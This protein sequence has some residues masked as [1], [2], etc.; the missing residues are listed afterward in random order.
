M[1]ED[2]IS[3]WFPVLM[4]NLKDK[5]RTWSL[6]GILV[7]VVLLTILIS[8][9]TVIPLY[10]IFGVGEEAAIFKESTMGESAAVLNLLFYISMVILFSVIL[11]LLLRSGKLKLIVIIQ[12]LLLSYLTASMASF[13]I[14]IWLLIFIA[15]LTI[16]HEEFIAILHSLVN[17]FGVLSYAIFVLFGV[18]Q[19]ISLL[20]SEWI[21]LRNYTL[22]LSVTWAGSLIG[23]F[24]GFYTPLV[25]MI[26]FVLYDI[27]AVFKGPIK[28]ISEELSKR[29]RENSEKALMLGLGDIFFYSL[30]VSYSLAYFGEIIALVVGAA[31]IA[32]VIITGLILVRNLSRGREVTLPALPIPISLA[33]VIII[34]KILMG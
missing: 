7:R 10:W 30:A 18:L 21:R 15:F 11:Y 5:K 25:L 16:L 13:V 12:V 1:S 34:L 20:K 9:G 2:N 33:V 22:L 29:V 28:K 14:P 32:G 23:L 19:A 8:I 4:F 17:W 27:F 24:M 3:Q 31:I 6:L 26:G